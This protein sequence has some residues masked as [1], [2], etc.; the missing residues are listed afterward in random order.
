[1]YYAVRT[2]VDLPVELWR[3]GLLG[4]EKRDFDQQP[5]MAYVVTERTEGIGSNNQ[6]TQKV[7]CVQ[8]PTKLTGSFKVLATDER[9]A[10]LIF[11]LM[12]PELENSLVRNG[13]IPAVRGQ[14]LPYFAIYDTN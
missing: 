1:V 8:V 14:Q 13:L 3:S 10:R 7:K 11:E 12:E 5:A 9:Q 4:S 6:R 2:D